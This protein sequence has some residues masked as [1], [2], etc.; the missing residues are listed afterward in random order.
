MDIEQ[1]EQY[2]FLGTVYEYMIN[3]LS[4][5]ELATG[6]LDPDLVFQES[7]DYLL[8]QEIYL[9]EE[10]NSSYA[11]VFEDLEFDS[12]SEVTPYEQYDFL[13]YEYMINYISLDELATGQCDPDLV[14]QES[15][16]YLL[17]QEIYP[18]EERYEGIFIPVY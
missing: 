10:S 2:R 3:Y 18:E 17:Q 6:Q 15:T 5:E 8:H 14:Y 11:N 4:H 1:Y 9:E 12:Y 13:L 16:E 7:T